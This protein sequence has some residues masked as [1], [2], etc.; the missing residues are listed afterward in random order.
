MACS[1]NDLTISVTDTQIL[2]DNPIG[3][4]QVPQLFALKFTAFVDIETIERLRHAEGVGR[5]L[6]LET[7]DRLVGLVFRRRRVRGRRPVNGNNGK[8]GCERSEFDSATHGHF[9]SS[10]CVLTQEVSVVFGSWFAEIVLL[11]QIRPAQVR[12]RGME[13]VRSTCDGLVTR[14]P[15]EKFHQ[16]PSRFF[17]LR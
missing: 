7:I 4:I 10:G 1:S 12:S 5:Y 3:I 8:N 15:T 2:T 9:S 14:I 17:H 6:R 13:K 11:L 16:T